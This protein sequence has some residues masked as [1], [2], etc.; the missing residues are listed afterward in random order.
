M[1]IAFVSSEVVPFAKTGGLADVV[2]ALPRELEKLGH[3]PAVFVPAYRQARRCGLSI[4]PTDVEVSVLVG[5]KRVSGRVLR[6][7][8]PHAGVPVYLIEQDSY[9]DRPQLYRED[10]A[11]YKDNCERFAFFSRAVMQAISA[12]GR[13]FDVLH[14]NDWQTGLL[15]AYLEIEHGRDGVLSRMASLLT[16]H[17]MAYQGHFWHWDMLL[18]GLDWKY[19][20]W[21]QMEFYG[22][23]NLLKTGIVFANAINTVSPQY[24]REIQQVPTG[25]GLEAVLRHRSDVLS[26]IINGVNYDT[27]DPRHDPLIETTYDE[28]TWEAGKAECK[29]ALQRELGLPMKPR[30]PLVGL[31][32]R[33]ADQKGWDLV[34]ELM[35]HWTRD[36]EVQW[37]VLGTGEEDHHQLLQQLAQQHPD[38][39]A[40]RLGFSDPLAHRI[41]AGSDMFLMASRYEPCGLNQ[42]YSLR[43]GAVPIVHHTGGLADTIVDA[44]PENLDASRANGFAFQHY[45]VA[46]LEETLTRACHLYTHDW[47]R[48]QQLV[49]TGMKQDWSW[50]RSARQYLELY[51]RIVARKRG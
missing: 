12:L 14:C 36:R 37:V 4:E 51:A 6:S 39:V 29:A 35:Q 47:P 15:P 24:A 1:D 50:T 41:E 3:H 13:P 10:G 16:I 7:H 28:T 40:V 22:H 38:R 23:L 48:W 43:Y 17:N 45:S 11:D 34:D 5:S 27:W 8:L 18:T 20:N 31:V 2:E 33:L 26:G 42:L 9:F 44:S 19:F 21:H 32:G 25:C 49:E 30:C 46:H